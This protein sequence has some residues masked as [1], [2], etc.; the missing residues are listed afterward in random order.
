M[1]RDFITDQFA[2]VEQIYDAFDIEMSEEGAAAMQ[3]FIAANPPGVHGVHSYTP[4]EYSID[5]AQVRSEF[6]EYIEHFDLPPE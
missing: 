3:A 1:F 4:E 6:R 2:V 5:P